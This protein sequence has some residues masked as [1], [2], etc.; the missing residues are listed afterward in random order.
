[1]KS[2]CLISGKFLSR[3]EYSIRFSLFSSSHKAFF[4]SSRGYGPKPPILRNTQCIRISVIL[5]PNPK[6]SRLSRAMYEV[7]IH[8]SSPPNLMTHKIEFINYIHDSQ[9]KFGG[10]GYSSVVQYLSK[11]YKVLNSNPCSE[12]MHTLK[13]TEKMYKHQVFV[14]TLWLRNFRKKKGEEARG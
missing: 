5:F 11:I 12:Y 8:S 4:K 14:T 10:L 3:T 13:F 9:N 1:M 6:H 2:I 7:H